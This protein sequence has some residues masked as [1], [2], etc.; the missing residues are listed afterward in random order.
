MPGGETQG[1]QARG[2][3]SSF[4]EVK[5]LPR[6][7]VTGSRCDWL[8]SLGSLSLASV[9]LTDKEELFPPTEYICL[10]CGL[11]SGNGLWIFSIQE[12]AL[13]PEL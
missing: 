10:P 1:H 5:V 8:L 2:F 9:I 13:R 6:K 7:G 4:H 12:C 3:P 11:N